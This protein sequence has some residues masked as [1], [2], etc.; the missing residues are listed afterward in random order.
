MITINDL[1][2][3]KEE[4]LPSMAL[5]ESE[6]DLSGINSTYRKQILICRGTGCTSSKSDKIE[7]KL[8][9]I[10][11]EKKLKDE[12]TVVRVGCF[13]LCEAG[14]IAVSYTHLTLPTKRIV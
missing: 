9:E 4:T 2:K 5:R 7:A 3:I 1:K 6:F 12:V 8:D 11:T 13:G 14:P 10:L